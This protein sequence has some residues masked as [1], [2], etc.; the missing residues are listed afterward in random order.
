VTF[1]TG[2]GEARL[3]QPGYW[4]LLRLLA[5]LRLRDRDGGK[6]FLVD[7]RADQSRLFLEIVF[8]RPQN[9]LA[10]RKL[11]QGFACPSVL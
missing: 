4:G 2:A 9:P 3:T 7:L 10:M 6:R 5:P 11:M 8:D 1:N